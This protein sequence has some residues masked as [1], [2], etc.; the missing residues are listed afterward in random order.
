MKDS[1]SRVTLRTK[2]AKVAL[3]DAMVADRCCGDSDKKTEER[4]SFIQRSRDLRAWRR[5]MGQKNLTRRRHDPWALK[6]Y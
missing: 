4:R 6:A 1:D 5:A 3:Q 2:G